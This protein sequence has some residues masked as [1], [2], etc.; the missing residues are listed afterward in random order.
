MTADGRAPASSCSSPAA[1]AARSAQRTATEPS[2]RQ[3]SAGNVPPAAVRAV[4]SLCTTKSG[5]PWANRDA[6]AARAAAAEALEAAETRCGAFAQQ[7]GEA[8]SELAAAK[9]ECGA[10]QSELREAQG[11]L[12][13]GR[14]RVARSCARLAELL[15]TWR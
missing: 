7:L 10:L 14:E 6:T 4:R 9:R 3:I 2:G 5:T 8:R 13:L 11:G 1:S 15:R 12:A